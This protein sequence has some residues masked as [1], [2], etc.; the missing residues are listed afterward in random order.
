[1]RRPNQKPFFWVSV[2]QKPDSETIGSTCSKDLTCAPRVLAL[3]R[4][5][6]NLLGYRVMVSTKVKIKLNKPT[7]KTQRLAPNPTDVLGVTQ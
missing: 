5:R 6:E 3:V 2:S 7:I 4:E 1:M